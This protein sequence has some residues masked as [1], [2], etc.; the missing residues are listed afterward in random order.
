MQ[1]SN[2]RHVTDQITIEVEIRTNLSLFQQLQ[3]NDKISTFCSV[4]EALIFYAK[5]KNRNCLLFRFTYL[6]ASI[7]THTTVERCTPTENT[8]FQKHSLLF[9]IAQ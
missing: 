3:I 6:H 7:L 5:E 9:C 8:Y 2:G 1:L 4:V